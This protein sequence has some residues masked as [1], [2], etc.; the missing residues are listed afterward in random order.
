[1]AGALLTGADARDAADKNALLI[2]GE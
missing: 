2:K 1:M